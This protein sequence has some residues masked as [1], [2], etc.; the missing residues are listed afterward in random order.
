MRPEAA[1]GLA[2][3]V[4]EDV[5]GLAGALAAAPERKKAFHVYVDE[6][7]RALYPGLAE[8]ISQCRSADIG[9]V[10]ATQSPRDF[11]GAEVKVMTQVLQNTASKIILRQPDPESAS[12]CAEL[13]G[14]RETMNRTYQMIDDGPLMGIQSSGVYSDRNVHEFFVHPS[15]LKHLGVGEA[16]ILLPDGARTVVKMPYQAFA[17]RLAFKLCTP[18]AAEGGPPAL[19]LGG[20]LHE[21]EEPTD[22]VAA[23]AP[24]PIEPVEIALP[25]RFRAR[26]TVGGGAQ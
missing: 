14:T 2:R 10:L 5:K 12:L 26:K 4:L 13:G 22:T 17:P 3:L 15:T 8:L 9:L 18:C 21:T 6:A 24:G 19:D 7:G 25:Q 16:F 1:R 23:G 20:Q 11:D